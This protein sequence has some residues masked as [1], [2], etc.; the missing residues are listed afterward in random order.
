MRRQEIY[1]K[2]NNIEYFV[3][4]QSRQRLRQYRCRMVISTARDVISSTRDNC[5]ISRDDF[6]LHCEI[7]H[8]RTE[9]ES[10]LEYFVTLQS[11]QRLRQYRVGPNVLSDVFTYKIWNIIE[12]VV[13]LSR[14]RLRQYTESALMYCLMC[15]PIIYG[16]LSNMLSA[17]ICVLGVTILPLSTTFL[18]Y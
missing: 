3:T 8:R 6:I 11:R 18:N 9:Y 15:L 1:M 16:T 12:Y 7:K 13:S 5:I 4:L 10:S 14:Q 2:F 17:G